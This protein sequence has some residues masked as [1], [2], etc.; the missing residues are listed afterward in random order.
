[1][2]HVATYDVTV[3]GLD[4]LRVEKSETED[5]DTIATVHIRSK[6]EDMTIF[7]GDLEREAL[8]IALT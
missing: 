1:M 4:L 3:Y 2:Q 7:L 8:A 6:D 5:G